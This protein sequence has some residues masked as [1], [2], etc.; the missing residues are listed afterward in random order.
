VV[1]DKA[2]AGQGTDGAHVRELVEAEP[3]AQD[4]A[5]HRHL[6]GHHIGHT[7]RAEVDGVELSEF[8]QGR[9]GHQFAVLQVM[10]AAPREL[11]ELEADALTLAG[12]VDDL[13]ALGHD[14]LAD[15]VAGDDRDAVACHVCL[16]AKT[17]RR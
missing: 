14:F 4:Q 2:P 8:I 3:D 5:A 11:G 16:P 15:P 10:F 13:N 12:G 7:H 17:P 1:Q 9:L 6:L